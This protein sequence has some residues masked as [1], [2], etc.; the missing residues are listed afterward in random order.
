M[1]KTQKLRY[2]STFNFRI[3][4][5]S[6]YMYYYSVLPGN[7]AKLIENCILT[8]NNWEKL[9]QDSKDC[10]C[11]LLFTPLSNEID[12]LLHKNIYLTHVVNHFESHC[13]LS[14]KKNLFINLLRY[15][16]LHN[17]N[18]F[19]FFPLTIILSLNQKNFDSQLAG[20]RKCYKDLPNLIDDGENPCKL[21]KTYSSYFSVNLSK[22]VGS[23]QKIL[24]PKTHYTGCNIWLIKRV[25]L[26]RGRQIHIMS[27]V[28]K[29]INEIKEIKNETK[30]HYLILQ[31]YIEDP[32]LYYSKKFDIRI[33]VLF[34]YM[35][36]DEKYEFY[37]FKEGH[38]K[39]CSE[40]Y[41]MT[42]NNLYVHLTNYSVQKY[43][44]NFSKDDIGNEISFEK[45]Q[46]F[47]DQ[48]KKKINFK[49]DI[50]TNI[51]QIIEITINAVKNKI[52]I[53][54][55]K[56]CFEIFGYD[57]ILDKNYNPF[58]LEINTNPGYEESSPLI[59]MLV[60][61]MIDDAFRLTIDKLFERKENDQYKNKSKFHVEGYGDDENMWQKIKFK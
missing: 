61:R 6:K 14:N 11:N 18:L 28:D 36:R 25:N 4:N 21:D 60:P 41:N 43:N 58:L 8:R 37:V 49:E 47:L 27:N 26:N 2:N 57:F 48:K 10:R 13:E 19:Q 9:P 38:L 32:L 53:M 31:K 44:K 16:E 15:C 17:K 34:T 1:K 59:K 54:D 5:G 23:K 51:I 45:F 29:L 12:Y 55:R 30:L 52:N 22:Q 40:S 20:F 35:L 39:S 46:N 33:W 56:N 3:K 7:N 24:I 42:S 50:L